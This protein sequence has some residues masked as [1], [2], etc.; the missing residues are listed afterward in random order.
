MASGAFGTGQSAR[1]N[2]VDSRK[3]VLFRHSRKTLELVALPPSCRA[4]VTRTRGKHPSAGYDAE[5]LVWG[6]AF[7]ISRSDCAM[8]LSRA[9]YGVLKIACA[10][11]PVC[12][13]VLANDARPRRDSVPS[14]VFG[15]TCFH[16]PAGSSSTGRTTG[17]SCRRCLAAAVLPGGRCPRAERVLAARPDVRS[18]ILEVVWIEHGVILLKSGRTAR[19]E[20]AAR[21]ASA[22]I[23]RNRRRHF[24]VNC[25]RVSMLVLQYTTLGLGSAQQKTHGR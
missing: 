5:A 23:Q 7:A 15:A 6:S 9:R 10:I 1:L 16:V 12:A 11:A 24:G 13:I 22:R 21:N 25:S 4:G 8:V 2:V 19:G 3:G 18:R 20:A 17:P 14:L